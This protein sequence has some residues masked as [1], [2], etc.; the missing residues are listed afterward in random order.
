MKQQPDGR[1]NEQE[2]I[3]RMMRHEK[4]KYAEQGCNLI[5]RPAHDIGL[6]DQR[7]LLLVH[8]AAQ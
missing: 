1:D 4:I 8:S 5:H 6:L 3:V 2:V 7:Y